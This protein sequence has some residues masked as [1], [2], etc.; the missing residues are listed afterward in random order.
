VAGANQINTMVIDVPLPAAVSARLTAEFPDIDFVFSGDP[1]RAGKIGIAEAYF[2]WDLSAETLN[3][4]PNLRWYQSVAAGVERV[5][6]PELL[7]RDIVVTNNSGVHAVNIAEHVLAMM[8]AIS[9]QL[10]GLILNQANRHWKDEDDTA[11][12]MTEYVEVAGQT[13][14]V[15]GYGDIG[16]RLAKI[17]SGIGMTVDAVKRTTSGESDDVTREIAPIGE[18]G[19]L[20][21]TADHVAICLP[22]TPETRGLFNAETIAM[23]KPGSFLYNIGRGQ[24]IENAPLIAA[25]QSGHVRGAGLDVTDP[26]P[27]PAESPLW[28]LKNVL[29]TAHT[30]GATP[31]YWERAGEILITNIRRVNL[32]EM[33]INIV[34]Q[35]LGY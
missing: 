24:I 20:L 21:G 19:R 23:M 6:T 7:A 4:A 35:R 27:L 25:L 30:S 31:H 33:P 5:L 8:L 11:E 10:P 3:E 26:E 17:A 14:L 12:R 1:R 32:G 28:D 2:H 13:L 16:Q 18:L 9:R 22:L 29:I 15:I 34:N